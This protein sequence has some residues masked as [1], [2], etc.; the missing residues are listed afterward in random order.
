[1]TGTTVSRRAFGKFLREL[2]NRA[3]RTPLA[4]GLQAEVSRMTIT[5]LEDGELTKLTTPQLER[6][7]DFYG[8]EPTE[9]QEALELWSEV[10]EQAKIA[11]LQG[12]SKGYWQPYADQYASHLPH[13]LRLEAAAD[14]ITTHQLVHVPGLLQTPDYRRAIARIDDPTMSVVNQERR[15]ELA[16]RRQVKLDED[17][18]HLEA[19]LSEA[20][21]RHRPGGPAVMSAQLRWL[22]EASERD[23]ISIRVVPFDV[24]SHRGLSILSFTLLTFPRMERGPSEP[25]V[26][27]IERPLGSGD[28]NDRDDVIKTY[29]EAITALRAVALSE[30]D[31]RDMVAQ[32]AKEYE[33]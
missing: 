23:N 33:A 6:L 8:T 31:T 2:R 11:K 14:R 28:Y 30:G 17:G 16:T 5:R 29:R 1:M 7:L 22:A 21:L 13:L 25:P 4:A 3:G 10:R 27:Y 26:V 20:V 32:A 19:L 24:G 15:V 9:R 12:N 18:F